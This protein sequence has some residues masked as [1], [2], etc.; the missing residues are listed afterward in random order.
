MGDYFYNRIPVLAV[1]VCLGY[2]DGGLPQYLTLFA[3][4][5]ACFIDYKVRD[6]L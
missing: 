2:V 5:I 6:K 3:A 1:G 4:C